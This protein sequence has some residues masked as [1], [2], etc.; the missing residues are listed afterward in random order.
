MDW[1]LMQTIGR[2]HDSRHGVSLTLCGNRKTSL[3]LHQTPSEATAR[4][5]Q[6]SF[7]GQPGTSALLGVRS[8]PGQNG[9]LVLIWQ[10]A[11][12]FTPYRLNSLRY[13]PSGSVVVLLDKT[14]KSLHS[15]VALSRSSASRQTPR[16]W[17]SER[18][19]RSHGCRAQLCLEYRSKECRGQPRPKISRFAHRFRESS[20]VAKERD[21]LAPSRSVQTQ[22]LLE[23]TN[24]SGRQPTRS[25]RCAM[26]RAA[27]R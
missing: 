21:A 20:T 1:T 18:H 10:T 3:T 5:S 16:S 8:F 19:I 4:L 7:G 14:F 24:G 9:Q 2:H 15:K 25:D 13:T 11:K 17:H 22:R 26:A 23:T 27:C 6:T 12:R